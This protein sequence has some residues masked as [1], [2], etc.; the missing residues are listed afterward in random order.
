MEDGMIDMGVNDNT[1]EKVLK[2]QCVQL[3]HKVRL[4]TVLK[5]RYTKTLAT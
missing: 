2:R 3:T 5:D 1:K 4:R